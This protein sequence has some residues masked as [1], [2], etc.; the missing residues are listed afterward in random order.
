MSRMYAL[1]EFSDWDELRQ[2][3]HQL[4]GAAGS[5]GC[6]MITELSAQRER[7]TKENENEAGVRAALDDLHDL[8]RRAR[9][10]WPSS[11]G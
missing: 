5:H 4:K 11:T 7:S 2:V 9:A 1:Y 6:Q 8:C 3:A 10:G